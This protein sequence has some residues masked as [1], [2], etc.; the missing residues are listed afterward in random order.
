MWGGKAQRLGKNFRSDMS[1]LRESEG[2]RQH[3]DGSRRTIRH[4][5]NRVR[6]G[7]ANRH[8][9]QWHEPNCPGRR[10]PADTAAGNLPDRGSDPTCRCAA[11]SYRE[12]YIP[13]RR[14]RRKFLSSLC[15]RSALRLCGKPIMGLYRMRTASSPMSPRRPW[16]EPLWS[17]SGGAD[18]HYSGIVAEALN[19]GSV[20]LYPSAHGRRHQVTVFQRAYGPRYASE[21]H[22]W[23]PINIGVDQNGKAYAVLL[24]T[25]TSIAAA[26]YTARLP[27]RVKL[28]PLQGNATAFRWSLR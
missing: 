22:T 27:C 14:R 2:Q 7:R 8:R 12:S 21:G 3:S 11:P 23:L 17:T 25:S 9:H 1:L 20:V 16:A 18:E 6:S 28:S 5:E 13:P 26:P 15:A 19:I 24:P 4:G 10:N